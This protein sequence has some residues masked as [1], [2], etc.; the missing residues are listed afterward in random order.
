MKTIRY[1]FS[2]EKI[3]EV[4]NM[5]MVKF[6][7]SNFTIC[8]DDLLI[9]AVTHRNYKVVNYLLENKVNISNDND[10]III[11]ATLSNATINNDFKMIKL[12]FKNNCY[13]NNRNMIIFIISSR[14]PDLKIFRFLLLEKVHILSE[15]D[16]KRLI[17]TIVKEE[18]YMALRLLIKNDI[19]KA[20][21]D[22]ALTLA[23][24]TKNIKIIKLL[25]ANEATP[26]VDAK[27]IISHLFNSKS[28][29]KII[30]LF[31]EFL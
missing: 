18:N 9:N 24:K 1:F 11:N 28:N 23:I 12:L 2:I 7:H 16:K 19:G 15:S 29:M 3:Y 8:L 13:F 6:L 27:I 14:Y 22:D 30:K 10:F 21:K 17:S 20:I 5:N 31:R 25:L 4:I 26:N